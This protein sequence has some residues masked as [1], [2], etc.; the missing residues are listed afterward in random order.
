MLRRT[1]FLAGVFLVSAT[2]LMLQTAETRLLSVVAWYYLAFFAISVAILGLTIGATWVY[3]RRERFSDPAR[4]APTLSAFA[5]LSAVAV[6]VSLLCQLSLITSFA[7]TLAV[8][9]SWSLLLAA[10]TVPY[11]FA[12]VVLSLALTRSPF[13]V[14]LLFGIDLVGAALGCLGVVGLLTVVD[15][16]TAMLL[17]GLVAA[18]GAVAFAFSAPAR[19]SAGVW[20][21]AGGAWWRRPVPVAVALAAIVGL[22]VVLP[23]GIKPIVVKDMREIELTS[24]YEKWNP[25]SR[26]VAY[27]PYTGAPFLWGPSPKLPAGTQATW[28]QMNIDGMAG[29]AMAQYDGTPQSVNYL[30]YDITNLAYSL[31]GIRSAAIVGVGGGRDL[32]SARLFGVGQITGIELNPIFVNLDTKDPYYRSFGHI[33]S[34]PGLQLHVDD[35]RNWFAATHQRFD[36]IEM[37]MIDTWAATGAGAFSLSENGLYTLE[38]W[39]T[40]LGTLTPRGVFTV[41]RWYDPSNLLETGRVISLATAAVLDTGAPEA[42][43]HLFVATASNIATLVLSKRPFSAAQVALLRRRAQRLGFGVLLAPGQPPADPVLRAIVES[44]TIDQINAAAS[45]TYLDLSVPT[46]NRPFFFNQLRFN[47]IRAGIDNA[48]S[49]VLKGNLEASAVLLLILLISVVAVLATVLLPLRRTLRRGSARLALGGSAYFALIGAGFILAEIS[50]IEYLSVYLGNPTYSLAVCLFSLIL[51]TG[52]G[53]LVSG[54]VRI[55]TRARFLV[56]GL[57]TAGCVFALDHWILSVIHSTQPDSLAT[58]ILISIALLMPLGFLFGFAFPTGLRVTS[59]IDPEP[60][61][62]F[63]GING[64]CGV[65]G[66]VLAVIISIAFGINVA[67]AVAGVC[68]LALIVAGQYLLWL[69]ARTAAPGGSAAPAP[70]PPTPE[71]VKSA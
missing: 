62:W 37:S 39:R 10:M 14:S 38:G 4:L 28:I 11:V 53:S 67:V 60:A 43:S 57:L 18:L 47:H 55:D 25:Y 45:R 5:L 22:N 21:L 65:T 20:A 69:R 7:A 52:L 23:I 61:P 24:R 70:V 35:A 27:K 2:V 59:D 41:S 13:P 42:S 6:P 1:P 29:T 12:G 48:G 63:W 36:S 30:R 56:W 9:A 3:L 19:G 15:G 16:P 17:V 49:G 26:I 58:R 46:D 8:I 32:V 31:P 40:F 68:Y 64:A 66:S 50:L 44:H 51:A 54:L 33:G 34:I 71:L